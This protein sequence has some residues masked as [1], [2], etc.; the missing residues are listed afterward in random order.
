[1]N[2]SI[3]EV[4][5]DVVQP[6]WVNQLWP[7]RKSPVEPLS[8]MAYLGG[9][10]MN[11]KK[12]Y[13]NEAKF[14]AAMTGGGQVAGVFSGH[15]TSDQ[16]YRARGLFVFPDFQN[17]GVGTALVKAVIGAAETAGRSVC[18]CIPRATNTLFFEMSGFVSV[19]DPFNNGVEFGPNVY[20]ARVIV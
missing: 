13:A 11:I 8:S 14:F 12:L 18:W 20:M 2:F 1:M 17:N 5:F 19:S 16:Y 4:A 3:Q 15:P 6:I 7:G 9:Y 10:D